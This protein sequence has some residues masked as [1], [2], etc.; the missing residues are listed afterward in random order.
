M[1]SVLLGF[2]AAA[3]YAITESH[4]SQKQSSEVDKRFANHEKAQDEQY[5]WL[6]TAMEEM[7]KDI[8]ELRQK[9]N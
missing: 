6:R 2:L 9:R 7:H 5:R 3:G 8:R 1:A 4:E